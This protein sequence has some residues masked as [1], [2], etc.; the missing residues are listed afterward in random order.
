MC[1]TKK[2]EVVILLTNTGTFLSKVI[3]QYTNEPYTHVSIGFDIELNEIYS[4]GRIFP[5]NPL[6]GGFIVEDRY[7][8]LYSIFTN[9]NCAVYT[10]EVDRLQYEKMKEIIN[11]F[12]NDK[13]KYKYNFLGLFAVACNIPFKRENA[14]FCSQFAATVLE[15]S[16]IKIFN[17][18]CELVTPSD[19]RTCKH[20]KLIYSGNLMNYNSKLTHINTETLVPY[21]IIK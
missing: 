3:K 5:H 2:Y 8:G 20:L 15:G 10:L 14:Y 9:V 13:H 12:H 11:K 7:K 18:K 16:N 21:T 17:K 1:K 4:F 19:F 6:I